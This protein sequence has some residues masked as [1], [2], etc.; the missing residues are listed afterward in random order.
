MSG[1][2][3]QCQREFEHSIFDRIRV[4]VETRLFHIRVDDE[5]L[6]LDGLHD[7]DA[8][9]ALDDLEHAFVARR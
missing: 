5:P 4:H 8:Q 1:D 2:A 7:F 3:A 9:V 6:G